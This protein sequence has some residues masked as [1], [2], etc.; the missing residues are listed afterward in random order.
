VLDTVARVAESRATWRA[1]AAEHGAA[2]VLI[3]C[4]CSDEAVHE[5]RLA[6]RVRGIP[7]WYEVSWSDVQ[8]AKRRWVPWEDERLVL[9]ALDSP[10]SNRRRAL[11]YVADRS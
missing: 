2:F 10:E 8:D 5:G 7:G 6:G 4:V 1:L 9:D 3:E 11:T